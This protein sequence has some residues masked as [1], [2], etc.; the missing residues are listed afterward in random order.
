MAVFLGLASFFPL[1]WLTNT[2]VDAAFVWLHLSA[3][4]LSF[5]HHEPRA[6][7]WDC[8]AAAVRAAAPS[9]QSS[10]AEAVTV[11][12]RGRLCLSLQV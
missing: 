3:W 1:L 9:T 6:V 8:M 10:G 12:H 7:L 2:R 4:Q 11:F 5:P